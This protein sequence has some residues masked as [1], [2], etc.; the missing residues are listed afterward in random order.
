MSDAIPP[1]KNQLRQQLRSQLKS[2]SASERIV[3]S[4][5]A[6]ARLREQPIWQQANSILFYAPLSNELDL[7]PLLHE[8][9]QQ[10]KVIALPGFISADEMYGAYHVVDFNRDC[11]PG[12]FGIIEPNAHCPVIPLNQLDLVLVPGVGFDTT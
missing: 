8:A 2:L 11:A 6:I 5:A 12:K 7:S 10:K 4:T 1:Q 3:A 9:I